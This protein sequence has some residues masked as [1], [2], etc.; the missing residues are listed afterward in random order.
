MS[1]LLSEEQ[2]NVIQRAHDPSARSTQEF[3]DQR[4]RTVIEFL[5]TRLQFMPSLVSAASLVNLSHDRLRHLFKEAMGMTF[6]QYRKRLQLET[7]RHLLETEYLT[8]QQVMDRVGIHCSSH[9]TRDF[10][11]AYGMNPAQYRNRHP[12]KETADSDGRLNS[13]GI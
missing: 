13:D 12:R 1:K 10:K 2:H 3:I 7:A 6:D 8:I 5:Q 4:V 9:F 11:K